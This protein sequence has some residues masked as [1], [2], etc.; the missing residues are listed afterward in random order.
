MVKIVRP[1]AEHS[2]ILPETVFSLLGI[3]LA[4]EPLQVK[5]LLKKYGYM[6]SEPAN[7][8]SLTDAVIAA[9]ASNNKAFAYDLARLIARQVVPDGFDGFDNFG[10]AGGGGVT[11]G[12]DPI[13]AIA[14][15]IGSVAN[16]F[17]NAQQKKMMKKQA[18][19]QTMNTLFAYKAQQEQQAAAMQA[20]ARRH[21]NQMATLKVIGLV[22][23]GLLFGW[24][25]LRT[26][27]P[28]SLAA[29]AI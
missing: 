21:A 18:G 8:K 25:F 15:A 7:Y 17:G 26:M 12:T 4:N 22:A 10:T 14:G 19:A 11:V 24:Y 29:G 23:T 20:E 5:G 28:R 2:R 9:M 1:Q 3:V 27:K 6:V 13:S 16:L